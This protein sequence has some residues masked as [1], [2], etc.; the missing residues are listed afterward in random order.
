MSDTP[1][2]A[3]PLLAA[4]QAQK[5]VTH[6]EALDQLDSLVLLS[7][8]SRSLTSPPSSPGDGDRYIPA[9][10]AT[11]AWSGKDGKLA[12]YSGGWSFLTPNKGWIAYVEDE[13]T[14]AVYK[15]SSWG[16]LGR[17]GIGT[18]PD[19]TNRLAA[20]LSAALFTD[21]GSGLQFK[22]NKSNA[23]DT[24]SYLFQT[25]WSGRAEFGLVGGDDFLL[26]VSPDGSVWKGVFSVDRATGKA[27]F[28]R[29]SLRTQVDIVTSSGSWTKPDWA[30]MVTI[31]CIGGGGGGASGRRGA[32]ASARYGGGGG[33]GGGVASV[34]FPADELAASL[35]CTIG[36]GGSGASAVAVDNTN[37]NSGG[38]AGSTSVSSS[39]I[40]IVKAGGGWG[41]IGG[42]TSA[43]SGGAGGY[44]DSGGGNS[45]GA[46]SSNPGL[47]NT[48]SN[49]GANNAAGSGGGGGFLS[50]A[51]ATASG[52]I[53][54]M[55]SRVLG[56]SGTAAGGAAGAVSAAGGAGAAKLVPRG[57][58][59]GGG[60]GGSGNAAA[61]TAGGNGGA[62][63][64]PGGG[65]GGGGA[66]T[67]GMA[68]GAGGVGG[69]GEVWFISVG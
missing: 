14:L 33:G 56:A 30:R 38:A 54:G 50:A 29:G 9:S 45:G 8:A 3:L 42:T 59:G 41:A 23:G 58:G 5:H 19:N 31:V 64:I 36:A 20:A 47:G 37:G 11:G 69:R 18:T 48:T 15:G 52:G 4:S 6:N 61:T 53:G 57:M 63:G 34:Q 10:G 22:L 7:V 25:G 21:L 24:A 44:G 35:S 39:G 66:S 17:L 16:S 32:A 2:L 43:G 27:T 55:G 46:G 26:K 1:N 62:G 51:D 12:V 60:G 67:N 65:G 40:E 28:D 68:S 49:S 13:T